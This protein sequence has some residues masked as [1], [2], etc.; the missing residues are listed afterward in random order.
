MSQTGELTLMAV[1]AHPDDEAISTPGV[2]AKYSLEGVRTV[3]VTCTDGAL[4]FG[5][6][7]SNPGE[8]AHDPAALAVLRRAE[9]E[10]S[11]AH[12][13]V[14]HLEVLGYHDSGMAGWESNRHPDAFCNAPIDEVAD[15][16]VSLIERY[17]PQV[18]VTYDSDGGY[19]HPDHIRTHLVT[20]TA[21]E[22]TQV[23]SKVYLTART[24]EFRQRMQAARA[25]LGSGSG[26][27]S[28]PSVIGTNDERI[29]T[30]VDTCMV[31]DRHRAALA[32]HESQLSGTHWLGM[33][34]DV[35]NSLF[36]EETFV[37][38]ADSTGSPVP[39]DDLFAGLRGETPLR[40]TV[41]GP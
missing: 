41:T 30:R 10:R 1:H 25:T 20:M 4:G 18:L 22:R 6:G 3:V 24:V 28:P 39:E 32:A 14:R 40:A 37:R 36:D 34:A 31:A 15:R 35:F 11:C 29:T 19:G 2:L 13:G 38:Y 33:P 17:R 26:G 9:L 16:L 12:L 8:P 7:R 23:V 5:A 21:L 27:V